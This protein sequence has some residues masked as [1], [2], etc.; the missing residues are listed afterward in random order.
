[1]TGEDDG[2]EI[3]APLQAVDSTALTV[4]LLGLTSTSAPPP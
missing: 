4:T 1:M 2:V 3:T